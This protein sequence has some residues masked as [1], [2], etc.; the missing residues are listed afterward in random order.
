MWQPAVVI[1]SCVLGLAP[2]HAQPS[3][4][5]HPTLRGQPGTDFGKLIEDAMVKMH[6][7]MAAPQPTGDPDRDF[8]AMM[9]PHHQGAVDM[10]RLLLL[11]GRD[12]L[13]RQLAT[14]IIAGQQAEIDAMK[15]R[16]KV[17]QR[18]PNPNPDGF[19]AIEGTRGAN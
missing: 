7:E 2:A 10:A 13:V 12:P 19:P 15:A 6:N 9:I 8:L 4:V 11:Y 1:V 14:E 18:G 5:A 3:H 16:L 17:L